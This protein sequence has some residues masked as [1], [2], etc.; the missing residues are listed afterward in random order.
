M[1]EKETIDSPF[2][3][4]HD[5]PHPP[6]KAKIMAALRTLL[7]EKEFVSIT[8]SDIARNAGVTEALIYKYFKDK[9]DLLHQVL[10]EY[11]NFYI[12]GTE[13]EVR[14]IKGPLNQ[15]RKLIWS[16]INMY[17]SNRV[18]ARILLLEVRNFADYFL[19]DAYQMVK[20]YTDFLLAVI[21]E[22]MKDGS[23]RRDIPA[24]VIRQ[25]ILGG[26]EHACLPSTIFSRSIDPVKTSDNLCAIV[27]EGITPRFQPAKG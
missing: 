20:R 25:L 4:F 27:L 19:S 1:A 2:W 13:N 11:L 22:G 21:E 3:D 5:K 15:L 23:I 7:G 6:G 14:A 9:R 26:I 18:F 24:T 16:H 12:T 10:A 8:I 17:D